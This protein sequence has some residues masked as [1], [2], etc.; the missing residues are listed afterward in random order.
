MTKVFTIAHLPEDKV[1]AWLQHLRD[2]D[3]QNPGCHFEVTADCPEIGVAEAVERLRIAPPVD[4]HHIRAGQMTMGEGKRRQMRRDEY[5]RILS[6]HASEIRKVID[7]VTQHLVDEGRIMEAGW[8]ALRI[9]SIPDDVSPVRLDEM[10]IMFF[11]GAQ[12]LFASIYSML[13]PGEEPTEKDLRRMEGIAAEL[14]RFI[15]EYKL[16]HFPADG[17]A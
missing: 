13:D 12:H 4:V 6:G 7:A 8:V 17:T 3:K 14:D 9:Q 1:Q 10:R 15:E 2:F 16:R 11:A 5:E